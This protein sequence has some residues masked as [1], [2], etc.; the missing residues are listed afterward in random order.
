MKIFRRSSM[1][2]QKPTQKK[3]S[4]SNSPQTK[5]ENSNTPGVQVFD[6]VSG[7]IVGAIVESDAHYI[8]ISNPGLLEFQ[9]VLGEGG[10][11]IKVV[12]VIR[13]WLPYTEMYAL[14]RAGLRGKAIVHEDWLVK[15]H[16]LHT[17]KVKNG[18]FK[19]NPFDTSSVELKPGDGHT[20]LTGVEV[21]EVKPPQLQSDAKAATMPVEPVTP[22][23]EG[24]NG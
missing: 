10:T 23:N 1:P 7:K 3:R 6:T 5:T 19:L 15:L 14:A 9:N 12:A 2:Q 16:T 17:E 21:L 18:V 11:T 4:G 13:G 24:A 22:P 20:S 8:M